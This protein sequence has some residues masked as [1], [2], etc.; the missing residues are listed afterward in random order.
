MSVEHVAKALPF[1][2]PPVAGLEFTIE[3]FGR[4]VPCEAASGCLYDINMDVFRFVALSG[5]GASERRA[6]SITASP[7]RRWR[8]A[9]WT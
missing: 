7:T 2:P 3:L 6:G 1:L 8:R 5:P 9:R 4:L